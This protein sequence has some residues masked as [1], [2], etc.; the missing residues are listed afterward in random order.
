MARA[1]LVLSVGLRRVS[2]AEG[3]TEAPNQSAVDSKALY[4]MLG[5]ATVVI[6]MALTPVRRTK[7]CVRELLAGRW[8]RGRRT[9]GSFTSRRSTGRMRS[10]NTDQVG[11]FFVSLHCQQKYRYSD[12]LAFCFNCFWGGSARGTQI[13]LSPARR[14]SVQSAGSES[15]K[16]NLIQTPV[17]VKHFSI[18]CA[19]E[20]TFWNFLQ[21]KWSAKLCECTRKGK[22]KYII[23]SYSTILAF[24]NK[25]CCLSF[26]LQPSKYRMLISLLVFKRVFLS[27]NSWPVLI[28]PVFWQQLL[29]QTCAGLSHQVAE[30]FCRQVQMLDTIFAVTNLI[31]TS[32]SPKICI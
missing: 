32:K 11:D 3:C 7:G 24:L 29:D 5:M 8:F 1:L 22:L 17:W 13:S 15:V 10:K 12:L 31:L 2:P 28:F 19:T 21:S 26:L 16:S 14:N 23:Y 4:C 18:S 27:K 30:S 9:W 20:V 25:L 6:M